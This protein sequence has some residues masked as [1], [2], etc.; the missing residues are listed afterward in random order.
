MKTFLVFL[1]ILLVSVTFIAYQGDL[2]HYMQIQEYLKGLAEECALGAAMYYETEAFGQ[3]ALVFSETEANAFVEHMVSQGQT[4]LNEG[5][6]GTL[7]WSLQ[8]CDEA[9]GFD[10]SDR[11]PATIVTLRY[12]CED[13][14]RLPFLRVTEISR[15]A[16]YQQKAF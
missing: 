11:D 9:K 8:L 7:T 14:F 15:Q 10:G 5:R 1:S 12:I 3:G 6:E 4:V 2:A 16:K 13:L